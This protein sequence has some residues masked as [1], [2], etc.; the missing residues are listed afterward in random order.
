MQA[1]GYCPGCYNTVFHLERTKAANHQRRHNIPIEL[2]KRITSHC[3]ICGFNKYVHLHHLDHNRHNN[4]EKNLIGLCPN[5]HQMLHT[6]KYR[7]EVLAQIRQAL[8]VEPSPTIQL[9]NYCITLPINR[10]T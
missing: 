1:K 2:Y 5:H 10:K 7:E 8:R 3:L 9:N 6:L 4:D